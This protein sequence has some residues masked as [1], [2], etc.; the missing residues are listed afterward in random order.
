MTN[1]MD[2]GGPAFPNLEYVEGQRDGHGDTIDGYTV[3]T[4]GMSLRDW[5]AGQALTGLLAACEISCPASLF[6]KEA[7][8]AADAMLAARAMRSH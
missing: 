3:A 5:F 2:D 7:Y 8:A 4:G 6:A 1:K